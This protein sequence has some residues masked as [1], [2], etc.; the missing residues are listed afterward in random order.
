[1]DK[2]FRLNKSLFLIINFTCIAVP[3]FLHLGIAIIVMRPI[4]NVEI[5]EL[6]VP[7]Y[8]LLVELLTVIYWLNKTQQYAYLCTL[9]GLIMHVYA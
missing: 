4:N 1:M 2:E 6:L 8:E 5:F 9:K 3:Q 7:R